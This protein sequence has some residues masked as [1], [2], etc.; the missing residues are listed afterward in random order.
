MHPVGSITSTAQAVHVASSIRKVLAASN[1]RPARDA[2]GD[3][4]RSPPGAT[5]VDLT[6]KG[7]VIDTYA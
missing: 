4:D 2:D 3:G 5:G 6:G 1:A 7:G